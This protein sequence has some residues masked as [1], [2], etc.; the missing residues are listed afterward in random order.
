VA[1]GKIRDSNTKFETNSKFKGEIQ[2][3][4]AVIARLALAVSG[5]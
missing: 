2:N 3:K 4:K 5:E 1:A